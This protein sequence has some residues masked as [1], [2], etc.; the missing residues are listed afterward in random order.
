MRK[1]LR[2]VY[3]ITTR[4]LDV[5]KA[6]ST[7]RMDEIKVALAL[8]PPMPKTLK[9]KGACNGWPNATRNDERR[10][11]F[12]DLVFYPDGRPAMPNDQDANSI[13]REN[14]DYNAA[15]ETLTKLQG[16]GDSIRNSISDKK[17]NSLVHTLKYLERSGLTLEDVEQLSVI[18]V[19]GTKGKGSTCALTESI[20]RQ[21]GARTGFFSSP[22][23]A[24]TNERIRINGDPLPKDKFT[25]YFWLVYNRML[26]QREHEKDMPAFFMFL[27]IVGFHVFIAER[28]D[29][30]VLEV[31]LGG[32]LDCTNILRNVRTA[33]ITS[34]ALE[35]TALL[36]NTLRQIA[37]QKAGIIKP[38]AHVYTHVTQ[39]ECLQVIYER[40]AERRAQV[41]QVPSTDAYLQNA[42]GLN[43]YV[44][45]NASLAIQL[46]YDW[47]RQTTGRLHRDYPINERHITSEVLRGL[48]AANWPGRCQL[49]EYENM[50][51]HLDGAH[52]VESIRVCCDWY[53]KSIRHS[54]NPNILVF[55]RT[56]D[57]DPKAILH[58]LRQA[59]TFD[60][61]C[62]VPNLATDKP[63]DPNQANLHCSPEAQRQRA[64]SIAATWQ[65]LC[66]SQQQQPNHGQM[67]NTVWDAFVAI[68]T[69][70]PYHIQ[71]DVLITGSIHL[72]GAVITVLNDF[73]LEAPPTKNGHT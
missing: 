18:H 21:Y 31:G 57:S 7:R 3:K 5:R 62:F 52:T 11:S 37:W 29:V 47:L 73:H 12:A 65:Q 51:V 66:D 49:V 45:L 23:L 44:R 26:V 58:V 8:G 4:C 27:T 59:C 33:G 25:K 70:Y 22:H 67:Y 30:V 28:V 42:D 16:N 19:A 48:N 2:S 46:T 32:E 56:G 20:L 38:G 35:H 68:R 40:A 69:R 15:I 72:L 64:Q 13:A 17:L 6:Y 9:P 61:V 39:P 24:T 34:L 43:E 50:R 63:N 41:F 60:M 36:G 53:Q 10:P 71:L 14:A 55:N 1:Q 54:R